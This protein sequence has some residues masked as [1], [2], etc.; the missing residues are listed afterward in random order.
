MAAAAMPW[1]TWPRDRT[2]G[3]THSHTSHTR[4]SKATTKS[5]GRVSK[6]ETCNIVRQCD[7]TAVACVF[8]CVTS[9]FSPNV[10]TPC[11]TPRGLRAART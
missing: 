8:V 5:R 7:H 9:K 11:T 10:F 6:D 4:P 3:R 2:D 1:E